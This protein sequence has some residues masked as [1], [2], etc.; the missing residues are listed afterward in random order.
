[1]DKAHDVE[2]ASIL[3]TT[4]RL[5]VDGRDYEIDLAA[6]SGRL[7]KATPQQRSNFI[8]SPSG[9]G[10]HWPDIDE[11]LSIDGLIAIVH[12]RD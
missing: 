10:I 7:A 9:Y 5:R 6:Q 2:S 4:I 8:V 11:D 3:G 12:A 1:M